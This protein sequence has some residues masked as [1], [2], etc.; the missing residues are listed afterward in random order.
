MCKGDAVLKDVNADEATIF[1]TSHA[2]KKKK[3][4]NPL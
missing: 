4:K 1:P 3:K 2:K